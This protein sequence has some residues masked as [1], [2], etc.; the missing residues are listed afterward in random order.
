[1]AAQRSWATA[2]YC[3]R[4]DEAAC[5][6]CVFPALL[7]VALVFFGGRAVQRV[8]RTD[9]GLIGL[10][11]APSAGLATLV[12]IAS[13]S[14]LLGAPVIVSTTLVLAVS[15]IGLL[16]TIGQWQ[17]LQSI[18]F[19][20]TFD[21]LFWVCVAL[22]ALLPVVIVGVALGRVQAPLSQDD[23]ALHVEV[24]HALRNGQPWTGWYPP[25]LHALLA[26]QLA[27]LPWLDSAEGVYQAALGL[28]IVAPTVVLGLGL[29]L[30][31]RSPLAA[32]AAGA[33]TALT[34]AFP[35]SLQVWGG[36]PLA[37]ALLLVVG[38]WTIALEYIHVPDWRWA[39]LLGVMAGAIVLVHGTEL[40][41]AMLGLLV[42]GLANW[43]NQPGARLV[44]DAVVAAACAVLV[45]LPYL[46][47]LLSW[48]G[49]GGA[50]GVGVSQAVAVQA[51]V[52][53]A[54]AFTQL[55]GIVL[56]MFDVNPLAR[57]V[58][59]PLGI[60]WTVRTR[61]ARSL[62]VLAAIF[63]GL[64]LGFSTLSL[65]AVSALY[66]ALY[67]WS[68]DYRLLYV[69]SIAARLLE[70]G[71]VC[72]L[73]FLCTRVWRERREWRR[74][75]PRAARGIERTLVVLGGSIFVL[76]VLGVTV[77]LMVAAGRVDAFTGDDAAAMAW[78]G[79]NVQRGELVAN[80]RSADAG[81]WAPE[82]AGVAILWP[83]ALPDLGE[84]E[85]RAL[86][87]DNIGRLED[88]PE[89]SAAACRLNVRYVYSGAGTTAWDPRS[90]P[91]LDAMRQSTALTE[92]FRSGN[93]VVFRTRLNCP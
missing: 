47:A 38:F 7:L 60:W 28:S 67:P 54:G 68:L 36:W 37:A 71:G 42:F 25:G 3:H 8:L 23:G 14:D 39:A 80:D 15:G 83:R 92:A 79:A 34:F 2:G 18:S 40:F 48:A 32:S 93:A 22:T 70:G 89:A 51:N 19:G 61:E 17:A 21:A 27:G 65:P 33:L 44:R 77:Q 73:V 66:A 81:I 12:A 45:A 64:T 91:P 74:S 58:L 26:A 43:R 24:V 63:C 59:L 11:L 49:E 57:L 90:F 5:S 35:Y 4:I 46:P 16:A 86:V 6:A 20:R 30:W 41:T 62:I 9:K 52:Q 55:Q 88:V 69:A 78:L 76:S 50:T 31:R 29:V 85:Q 53:H 82:K 87:L 10:A 72:A 1:M 75:H 84:P 56:Q 13:W